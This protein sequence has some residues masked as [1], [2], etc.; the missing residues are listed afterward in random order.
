MKVIPT[1]KNYDTGYRTNNLLTPQANCDGGSNQQNQAVKSNTSFK[2]LGDAARNIATGTFKFTE[3]GG[4]FIQFLIVDTFS[5]ILPRTWVGLQR[6]KDKTGQYNIQAGAEEF[7]RELLSGPSMNLIPM[8]LASIAVR[9][10]MPSIKLNEGTLLGINHS[11]E[12]VVKN[13][14]DLSDK[15]KLARKLAEQIFD[16]AFSSKGLE[17]YKTKFV[18]TLEKATQSKPKLAFIRKI[19]QKNPDAF[20]AAEK[21]FD[22]LVVEMNNKTAKEMAPID[23]HNITLKMDKVTSS[24]T[25]FEDFHNYSKDII[26]KFMKKDQAQSITEF[27]EKSV[28]NVK[29][30]KMAI[31]ALAFFAVGGFLLYLPKVY[32]RGKISPAQQSAQRAQQEAAQGGANEA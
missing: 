24:Q 5:M 28:K 20:D 3:N 26:E 17:N 30:G 18:E 1:P 22:K 4:F 10:M 27:L 15:S 16:D 21:E 8:A 2:G 6:D 32:Q 23:P 9:K 11:F 14:K 31:A 13:N 12:N 29:K 25:F 7:G 19:S